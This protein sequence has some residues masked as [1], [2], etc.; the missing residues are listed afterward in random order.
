ARP[1][2]QIARDL[3]LRDFTSRS[4]AGLAEV[5]PLSVEERR[6]LRAADPGPMPEPSAM[7]AAVNGTIVAPLPD[8]RYEPLDLDPIANVEPRERMNR[9]A[10]VPQR[11]QC[12]PTLPRGLQRYAGVRSEERR[13]GK[14][15]R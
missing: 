2:Q 12:L 9:A 7:A 5:P 13:V 8:P 3:A 1:V 11:P 15:C 6:S 14:E 4:D 10:R